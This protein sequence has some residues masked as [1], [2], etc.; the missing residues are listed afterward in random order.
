M[1]LVKSWKPQVLF[2]VLSKLAYLSA[3]WLS[4][5]SG[6]L[7]CRVD[8]FLM[9][10]PRC[11]QS[12]SGCPSVVGWPPPRLTPLSSLQHSGTLVD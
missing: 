11:W 9:H 1:L 6:L 4:R 10:V 5:L 12:S 3:S 7:G 8:N 2:S